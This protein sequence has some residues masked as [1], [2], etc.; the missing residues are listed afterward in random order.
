MFTSRTST[1][2]DIGSQSIKLVQVQ[3]RRSSA[4]VKTFGQIPTPSGRMENGFITDPDV[5]GQELGKLVDRLKLRGAKTVSALSGQQVYT[6]L[7]TLPAMKLDEMRHAALYQATSFL[8]ISI[9]DVTTD[10]YP[11][12]YFEDEE[13]KKCE[14]FFVAARKAQA[15]NLIKTCQVAGLKLNR[16]EIEPLALHTLYHQQLSGQKVKGVLNIGATRSYLAI[17][18]EDILVFVRSI[19]FG[20]AA[21]Y[22]YMQESGAGD[23]EL[24]KLN[25]QD[26]GVERLMRDIVSELSR[27]LEYFRLQSKHEELSEII[28]CG[29]GAR[30]GGIEEYLSREVGLSVQVGDFTSQ[31]QLPDSIT[32]KEKSDLLY[33]YPVAL[34]LA[35]RG[36]K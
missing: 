28:L 1:G 22:Q 33:D 3:H 21:F 10:I 7:L 2:L 30:V 35:M 23:G 26:P 14:V 24:E 19:G 13:G 16:V 5:V 17:F 8:P 9:E 11:V 18:Q 34:G 27:F 4:R 15:E 36:V 32:A 25:C 31:I 29:G 6:R 12:R 20:C